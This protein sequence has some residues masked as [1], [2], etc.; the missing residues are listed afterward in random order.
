MNAD[1]FANIV[2][3]Q[4]KNEEHIIV[5]HAYN[6]VHIEKRNNEIALAY[7]KY[8]PRYEGDDEYDIDTIISKLRK[9]KKWRF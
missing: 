4:I 7:K 6:T 5:S 1:V 3:E 8:A 9:D 2:K